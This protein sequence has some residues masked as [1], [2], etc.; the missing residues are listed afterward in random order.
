MTENTEVT[1]DFEAE[2]SE[3]GWTDKEGWKGPEEKW[4]DAQ[5]FVERG[6]KI[7]GILKGKVERLEGKV[8]NL[9][10]SNRK[11]GEYHKQ[12]LET[13]RQKSAER[14]QTLEGELSQAVT[15]GDGANYT[16]LNR[17]I[18]SLKTDTPP[19]S[20]AGE[21]NQLAQSWASDNQWY[22]TNSKLQAFTD[23]I[24]DRLR[25]EGYNGQAYFSELTRQVKE[26]F[27]EEFTNPNKSKANGVEAGGQRS[28]D[29]SKAKTYD[30]LPADAKLACDD[31]V[32]Q[33]FMTQ[34]EYVKQ[35]DFE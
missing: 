11:F 30:A 32:S 17:E 26:N 2:A 34:A 13:Q 23:G 7:A 18:E 16:R 35:F 28:T 4:T 29:N 15:D 10:E 20:D 33:G 8:D 9:T 27:P 6:E 22:N 31:F 24:S 5:T 12:T 21:W 1:R 25:G 14:I 3:Q 19:P